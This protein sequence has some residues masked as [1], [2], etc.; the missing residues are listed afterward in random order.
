MVLRLALVLVLEVTHMISIVAAHMISIVAPAPALVRVLL[1]F[2]V[3]THRLSIL[4]ILVISILAIV[5]TDGRLRCSR[6]V[7]PHMPLGDLLST[8]ITTTLHALDL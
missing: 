4:T 8:T 3:A 1:L 5:D 2:K 7:T 6:L